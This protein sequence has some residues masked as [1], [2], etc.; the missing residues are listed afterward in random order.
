MGRSP[1][2]DK[3]GLK[4]GPWT[5]DEDQKLLAY[6]EEHGY[7]SWSDLPVRAGNISFFSCLNCYNDSN[8]GR[9][10]YNH[11]PSDQL[12][13]LEKLYCIYTYIKYS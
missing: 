2:L 1:C 8:V 4:K 11:Q 3:E 12:N 6:V 5:S 13:N 10:T 9:S 7:G